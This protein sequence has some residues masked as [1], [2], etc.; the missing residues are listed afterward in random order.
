MIRDKKFEDA[1][2]GLLASSLRFFTH[3][4]ETA[5]I[6]PVA[7]LLGYVPQG[8]LATDISL[9]SIERIRAQY[10]HASSFLAAAKGTDGYIV[11]CRDIFPADG[12]CCKYNAL[13]DPRP[14]YNAIRYL[15]LIG[16]DT[17]S[18]VEKFVEAL[19]QIILQTDS[20]YQDLIQR[21]QRFSSQV[22]EFGGM[23]GGMQ[24]SREPA[25]FVQE[26]WVAYCSR[27]CYADYYLSVEELL[28]ISRMTKTNIAVFKDIDGVL[29]FVGGSFHSD[30]PIICTKLVANNHQRV[31][32][33]FE[34]LIGVDD[35]QRFERE[36]R[37]NENAR[38]RQT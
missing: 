26:A 17:S 28:I 11:G 23:Q 35:L 8:T 36:N 14:H 37:E 38:R 25:N 32:S 15:F 18:T 22:R 29:N 24:I 6:L 4:M 2:R 31:R 19:D 30:E 34:R 5:F 9:R 1:K 12:P 13:F 3:D 20:A 21:A 10:P 7:I 33:H 27:I 16:G